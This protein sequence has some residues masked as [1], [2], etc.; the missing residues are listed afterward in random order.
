MKRF[1]ENQQGSI[2]VTVA[3]LFSALMG[4]GGLA[5]DL[6]NLY[7]VKTKMQNAAD[8]AVTGG[9]LELPNTTQAMAQARSLITQNNFDPGLATITFTQNAVKNPGNN[10]EINCTITQNVPTF[11]MG[12][13]GFNTV[14]VSATA[15]A[16]LKPG[17]A[18][19]PFNYTIFSGSPSQTLSL[20]G[21]QTIKG[22]VHA[23]ANLKINGSSHITGAAEGA[24]GVSI[25]GANDI[26]S[27]VAD[28]VDNI[29][30]NGANTIGAESGGAN[31]IDMPD[32]S[33]QIADMATQVYNSNKTFNGSV[34]VDGNIFVNGWVTLNGL[35][36]S[37]GA[38]LATGN[39]MVNGST[40]ISGANQV[41]LYSENGNI[42]INGASFIGGDSS[43]IL[44]APNG[45]IN[46]NG[47]INFKG[48]IIANRVNINGSGNFDGD[49]YPVTSLPANKAH[50]QL[51]Q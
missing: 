43:A 41:C 51:I 11:F 9:G 27:V 22:S 5:L 2:I 15:E 23:N 46:I 28:T 37:T 6:G 45:T 33:Q 17:S 10:P 13:F 7:V 24:T 21:S 19:G 48:R 36:D 42:T 14:T 38:I 39:I 16:I 44:Y 50:V 25:N 3:L 47:S 8:A 18:G 26:G 1:W 35:I 34:N 49:D 31:N 20:N 40:R 32:Y 29:R 30:V 12:V 4:F